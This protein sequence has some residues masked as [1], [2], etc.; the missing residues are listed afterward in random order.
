MSSLSQA[1]I[2]KLRQQLT[3]ANNAIVDLAVE[4]RVEKA[5]TREAKDEV[6][7]LQQ[8]LAESKS[9]AKMLQKQLVTPLPLHLPPPPSL[10]LLNPI[11]SIQCTLS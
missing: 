4:G 3:D 5:N 10:S 1:E 2:A 9:R 8:Q 7:R 11:S 6:E